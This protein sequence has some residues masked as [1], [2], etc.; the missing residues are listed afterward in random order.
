M[1]GIM[2]EVV[3]TPI[4][5]LP[6]SSSNRI[7][8]VRLFG[9]M[10]E[11]IDKSTRRRRPRLARRLS[12]WSASTA[13][14]PRWSC[15]WTPSE[16]MTAKACAHGSATPPAWL[17]RRLVIQGN[18]CKRRSLAWCRCS[19]SAMALIPSSTTSTASSWHLGMLDAGA[20]ACWS[21]RVS[22]VM[23]FVWRG[24]R[25]GKACR[26]SFKSLWKWR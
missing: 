25:R 3:R 5:P 6:M 19:P 23:Y 20:R 14:R 15:R 10:M 8:R 2:K 21:D 1:R 18:C 12:P 16:I 11:I 4:K 17:R 22:C 9:G 24:R 13:S 26:R 7:E